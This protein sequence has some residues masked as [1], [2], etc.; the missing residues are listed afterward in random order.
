MD[1]YIC[2]HI[3]ILICLQ[4]FDIIVLYLAVWPT[5]LHAAMVGHEIT[6]H[7]IHSAV[8]VF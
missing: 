3:A 2:K 4:T 7:K 8:T 1:F 5:S 6:R